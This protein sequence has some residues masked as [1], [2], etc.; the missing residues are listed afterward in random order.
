MSIIDKALGSMLAQEDE[1]RSEHVVYYLSKKL[2]D[3]ETRYTTVEKSCF[4]LVWEVQKL[5][6]IL[7][8]YQV[9]VIAQ[10][11]P[12]E[13]LFERLVITRKLSRWIILLAKFDLTYV[14]KNTIKGRAIAEFCAGHPV[15]GEALND[16]LDEKI[17]TTKVSNLWRMYFNGT[18]NQ[19][20]YEIGVLLVAPDGSHIPLFVKLNFPVTNNVAKYEACILGL[21]ALLAIEVREVEVYWDL[22]LIISQAQKIW[23][24]KE[25]HLKPYQAYV[26]KLAQKFDKVEHTF[27]P[28]PQNQFADALATL[29]SLVDIL[30]SISV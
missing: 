3:Y 9:L 13:Y 29:V 14:A 26:E 10:M 23:K 7:L 19:Y 22:A 12:L 8:S 2:K 30:D 18:A 11:D 27:I 20:G 28:R 6:H 4:T 5:R 25:E 17:L 15:N 24:T 21:E 16:F 1:D